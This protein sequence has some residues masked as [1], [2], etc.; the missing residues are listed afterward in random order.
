VEAGRI[1]VKGHLIGSSLSR[2]VPNP[3]Q[4]VSVAADLL[5]R[6]MNRQTRLIGASV[7]G[8]V[9]AEKHEILLS[10]ATPGLASVSLRS[11]TDQAGSVPIVLE[12]DMH[13]TAA[14]W[15]LTHRAQEKEDSILVGFDDGALG[16]AILIDGHPN[17]GC[18]TGASELGHCRFFVETER[19]YCG[20][21]GCLERICSSHF[22]VHH[23]APKG[24]KLADA[25][26]RYDGNDA[27][28]EEL[29]RYLA[30]GLANACNFVRPN[31]LVLV[32]RLVRNSVFSS[33]LIRSIRSLLLVQLADRVHIDL[34]DQPAL[35][36]A[37]TAG[38]LAL[39][40]LYRDG[41]IRTSG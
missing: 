3:Q 36:T 34:W 27:A 11:L 41:W 23:G 31:R 20:Q 7:T 40:S 6:L 2:E 16:A 19:C 9:D 15:V 28:L 10:S 1:G 5:K 14:R 30:M 22:L 25:V 37:E 24:T 33:L 4:L 35:N 32:S 29:V 38:W 18:A 17:R 8:F 13:A 39:A 21:T 12:N 26:A